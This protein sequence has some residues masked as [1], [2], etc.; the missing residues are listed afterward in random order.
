MCKN[1]FHV[2][3]FIESIQLHSF[4]LQMRTLSLKENKSWRAWMVCLWQLLRLAFTWYW[5][6]FLHFTESFKILLNYPSPSLETELS[7]LRSSVPAIRRWLHTWTKNP[8]SLP[9]FGSKNDIIQQTDEVFR[10]SLF[11]FFFEWVGYYS[12]KNTE[13]MVNI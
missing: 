3:Y 6:I 13:Y 7:R 9:I 12:G 2:H 5:L 1:V 10:N 4:I 11:R 8:M